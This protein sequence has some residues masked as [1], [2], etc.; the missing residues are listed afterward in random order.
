MNLWMRIVATWVAL[1]LTSMPVNVYAADECDGMVVTA[2][3]L[4]WS[5]QELVAMP[6][7][8]AACLA[9]RAEQKT[10]LDTVVAAQ[11]R[12]SD[13][14]DK[15]IAATSEALVTAKQLAQEQKARGDDFKKLSEKQAN[16]IEDLSAW[17]RSPLLWAG[18]G[19]VAVVVVV[20]LVG[21]HPSIT[22][23]SPQGS[24]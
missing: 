9:K 18:V 23:N 17:Y 11:E 14:Q 16:K 10:V 22:I 12:H 20:A 2:K 15:L 7:A 8:V 4:T 5:G 3:K 24:P 19:A 13:H 21:L 6:P 1:T